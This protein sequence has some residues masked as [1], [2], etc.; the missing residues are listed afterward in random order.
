MSCEKDENFR[1]NK[2]I[3]AEKCLSANIQWE[4]VHYE[5]KYPII[6]PAF[7]TNRLKKKA[8]GVFKESEI[9]LVH[10]RSIIAAS[11]GYKLGKKYKVKVIFDIRGFWADE[12]VDGKIW[13]LKNPLFLLV[14]HYFKRKERFLFEKVDAIVTLTENARDY[15]QANYKTKEIFSVVPCCVDFGHFDLKTINPDKVQ[16]LKREIGIP[17]QDY[18]LTYVG[19]LGARYM[20]EEML[21]FFNELK[22]KRKNSSFLFISKSDTSE[23]KSICKQIGLDYSSIYITSCEYAEIPSYISLGDASVFFIVSSFS[24]KAVSP[25]KQAEVMSLGLPIVAN[26][27]LGDTDRIL[28]KT[29]NGILINQFT[30]KEYGKAADELLK[31]NK[32]KEEI[33]AASLELFTL[34]SGIEQYDSLYKKL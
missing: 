9:D 27:G 14:Y 10:C 28:E 23:I 29:A 17:E 31:F 18:V 22:G 24:G 12:R 25:T 4:Y 33:R 2:D 13:N 19:S 6:S 11:I 15:I 32:S 30:K 3:V 8:E 21:E 7:N 26:T 16:E 1:K 34:K 5:N 20:L